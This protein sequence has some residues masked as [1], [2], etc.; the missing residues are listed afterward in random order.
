[1]Q[2][3]IRLRIQTLSCFRFNANLAAV[4]EAT[5]QRPHRV[6]SP[7]QT[8]QH[9][10]ARARKL[11]RHRRTQDSSIQEIQTTRTSSNTNERKRKA[12]DCDKKA[13]A[14]AKRV[15]RAEVLRESRNTKLAA[16]LSGILD[17]AS[18]SADDMKTLRDGQGFTTHPRLALTYFHCC[19][20]HL[21]AF[22]YNNEHLLLDSTVDYV[23]REA[24]QNTA[25]E[26]D[27]HDA[28]SLCKMIDQAT[29][30]RVLRVARL[31]RMPSLI[32]FVHTFR[33][34]RWSLRQHLENVYNGMVEFRMP[35]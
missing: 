30:L 3:P 2:G 32:Q 22:V 31:S 28:N 29:L 5:D 35:Y 23:V 1:M 34:C 24:R 21:D 19:A 20:Q 9:H 8:D 27:I 14:K 33:S 11:Q 6:R 26:G 17:A 10:R 12:G 25:T 16:L 18:L 13:E 15:C 7:Q 4:M